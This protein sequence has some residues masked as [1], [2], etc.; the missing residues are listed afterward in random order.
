[1]SITAG[2]RAKIWLVVAVPLAG[3][4]LATGS[5]LVVSSR[6]TSRLSTLESVEYPLTI[7]AV[8]LAGALK[9]QNKTFQDAVLLGEEDML[10]A[11]NQ[12]ATEIDGMLARMQGLAASRGAETATRISELRAGYRAYAELAARAYPAFVTGAKA[13]AGSL[14]GPENETTAAAV[15]EAGTRQKA[16]QA[17]LEQLSKELADSIQL[18]IESDKS[19]ATSASRVL[20]AALVVVSLLSLVAV[21]LVAGRLIVGPLQRLGALHRRVAEGQLLAAAEAD[22][23][24]RGEIGEV[25]ESLRDMG[26]ALARVVSEVRAISEH[27]S[28][29][30]ATV[31]GTT[32]LV[33]SGT[34]QQAAATQQVSSSMTQ[35]KAV[36]EKSAADAQRTEALATKTSD[37]AQQGLAAVTE[38]ARAMR[39][40]TDRIS[41]IEEIAYQTNLLALNAAIEAARAGAAGRGF[42][43]VAS[44]VR[45]L[46]ERSRT[47]ASGIAEVSTTSRGVAENA[48][49]VLGEIV[50]EIQQTAALVRDMARAA[51]EQ[52][53]G[54]TQVNSALQQLDSVAQQ[55]AGSAEDL[56]ATAAELASQAGQ[57][58]SAVSYFQID[59]AGPAAPTVQALPCAPE[60]RPPVRAGK[61]A[62]ASTGARGA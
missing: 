58:V 54:V 2:V 41:V 5:A 6:L 22:V 38:A 9:Q 43:V 32:D 34:S 4:A 12:M 57:L 36:V 60:S 40:I 10:A 29:A 7:E 59:G 61:P 8:A 62:G 19:Q 56:A 15:R 47:A 14:G 17:S 21:Y 24:D 53:S 11:G 49:R 52:S 44:E 39:E 31:Q 33:S 13:A 20:V 25:A 27:V 26:V 30:S 28:A 23:G 45:K 3:F 51:D 55:N 46:A 37:A 16:L 42:A 48:A 35:M 18:E 50:P 1:M